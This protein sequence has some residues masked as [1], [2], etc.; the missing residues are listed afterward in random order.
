[1]QGHKGPVSKAQV[2]KPPVL[3][4]EGPESGPCWRS[5]H[6]LPA[7]RRDGRTG[8][9]KNRSRGILSIIFQ[10]ME[11]GRKGRKGMDGWREGRDGGSR[12][13]ESSINAVNSLTL[14]VLYK[15]MVSRFWFLS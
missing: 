13:G 7:T 2:M 4:K 3:F 8:A 5:S 15:Y 12:G 6:F 1:M 14:K 10:K 11:G 9:D